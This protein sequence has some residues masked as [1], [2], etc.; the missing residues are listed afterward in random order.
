MMSYSAL[1]S[2][3]FMSL[4]VG[5]LQVV[6]NMVILSNLAALLAKYAAL[7]VTGARAVQ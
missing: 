7:R 1:L 3:P 4:I 6:K 5:N 2:M